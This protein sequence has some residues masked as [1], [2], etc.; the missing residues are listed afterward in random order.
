MQ[1]DFDIRED[2][3]TIGLP[4]VSPSNM[5]P[6]QVVRREVVAPDVVSV[7]IVLPGTQQAP[8]PYLPGQFVTLALPTPRET[9]YRSYSLC[10]GGDPGEPWEITVKRMEMGAVSTYFY[11]FV[12]K[13]TML[14]ASLPRGT[15]TLPSRLTPQQCYVF[16]AAGSGITPIMGMLRALDTLPPSE[17]PLVMLHYA[18]KSPEHIIFGGE[19]AHMDPDE[20][21]L[22]QYHYLSSQ[23][24]HMTAEAI[25]ARAGTMGARAHWYMCGPDQLKHD[26]QERLTRLGVPQ[27]RIH[28]EVFATRSGP[29]YRVEARGG[30]V[31]GSIR[32]LETGATLDVQPDETLLTALERHGYHPRFSCRAGAC[33]ECKLKVTEGEVD[34]PGES[35]T[36]ADRAEGYVLGCLARPIGDVTIVSGG[37]PPAGVTRV[38][39]A[40]VPGGRRS[41]SVTF[42]RTVAVMGMCA[43]L[44]GGWNLTDHRPLSWGAPVAAA[45]TTPSPG[46]Q[47]TAT[48]PAAATTG[49]AGA[50]PTATRPSSGGSGPAQ[51]TATTSSS[52]GGGSAQPTATPAPKPTAT[53]APKPTPTCVSTKSKPC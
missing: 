4:V 30:G 50:M 23:G 8:A 3:P 41:G 20:I 35:L 14:Y 19:L 43:V 33:G 22:R 45:A 47:S 34:P 28:S 5:L 6:V 29:A 52:G 48:G 12:Q 11:N 53:P 39:A 25:L 44:A 9:L 27:D 37:R 42:T 40:G 46:A 15:F 10:G 17:C 1:E 51:P 32:V 7:S 21:W 38:A 36:A 18:S 16:I 26:V 2:N 31:G 24:K 13:G 49:T